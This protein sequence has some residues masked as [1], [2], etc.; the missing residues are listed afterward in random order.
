MCTE[1]N[2]LE[3]SKQKIRYEIMYCDESCDM[4]KELRGGNDLVKVKPSRCWAEVRGTL[5]CGQ[6]CLCSGHISSKTCKG[7]Q[8]CQESSPDSR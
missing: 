6:R 2:S 7:K 3:T 5:V 4:D 1:G 8:L